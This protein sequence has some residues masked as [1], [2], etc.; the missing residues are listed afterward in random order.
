VVSESSQIAVLNPNTLLPLESDSWLK[1]KNVSKV[2][3]STLLDGH[4]GC[5]T[6]DGTVGLEVEGGVKVD[7]LQA[8][9]VYSV[10]NAPLNR[11]TE[12]S[13]EEHNSSKVVPDYSP[14]VAKGSG[15]AARWK[16]PRP[17]VEPGQSSKDHLD[18]KQQQ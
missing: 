16:G 11:L 10:G 7:S 6:Y 17:S 8:L 14:K 9:P 3:T 13:E 5:I 18:I 4:L 12:G 2:V 1:P 15:D